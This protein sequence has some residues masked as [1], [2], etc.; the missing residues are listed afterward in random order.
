MPKRR[1]YISWDD[2]FMGI[3]RLSSLRSKDPSTQVG[4]CIVNAEHKI[5]SVGYN[6]FP[7]GISDD[8][9]SWEKVGDFAETKYPYVCHAELN[10]I[11]NYS[12]G[13]LKGARIYVDLFPCNECSK[14]IIQAGIREVVYLRDKDCEV[15]RVSRAML[16][17]AGVHCRRLVPQM[18]KIVLELDLPD[19]KPSGEKKLSCSPRSVTDDKREA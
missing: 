13:S 15:F 9:F 17:A 10:A 12:G 19:K 18:K 6:G 1:D 14:A 3:A 11:L 7:T 8:L 16:E 4:A 5:L 2:Y